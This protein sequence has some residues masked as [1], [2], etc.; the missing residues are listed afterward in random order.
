MALA[1]VVAAIVGYLLRRYRPATCWDGSPRHRCAGYGSARPAGQ[2]SCARLGLKAAVLVVV[3]DIAKG[4]VAV[5]IARALS[6]E[7]YVKPWRSGPL[8]G[9][10]WP[11][12][13]AAA[14]A[15]FRCLAP[16]WG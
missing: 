5:L 3:I 9:H 15:A 11:C 2:M 7:P 16:S 12:T 6:D 10:V 1:V 14:D 4:T 13:C 8:A